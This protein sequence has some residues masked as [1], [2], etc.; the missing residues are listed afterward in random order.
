MPKL[1][2]VPWGTII[3][4]LVALYGAGLSTRVFFAQRARDRLTA[5][6]AQRRQAD[7]VTGWLVKYEGPEEPGK[8][9]YGLV[10]QNDSSQPVYDL[11]ANE[12][13]VHGSGYKTA[14]GRDRYEVDA[15]LSPHRYRAYITLV[16][17]GK[18]VTRIEHGGGGMYHRF[19]V[20]FAFRDAAGLYWL[21]QGDGIL[22]SITQHPTELYEIPGPAI[23][24]RDRVIK[25]CRPDRLHGAVA[26]FVLLDSLAAANWPLLKSPEESCYSV[27]E[28][29]IVQRE[30]L[31]QSVPR[32]QIPV[33]P[34]LG[35]LAAFS[36]CW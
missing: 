33:P 32:P 15:G 21:R 25:I 3:T 35:S 27:G 28:Q 19:G 17:P 18:T 24:W 4:G 2:E 22:R 30:F 7:Q 13:V 29:E 12:V 1:S 31:V 14:V 5:N 16:P 34:A 36:A 6:E 8:L 11:I 9:F 20:E 10:L 26:S 23:R